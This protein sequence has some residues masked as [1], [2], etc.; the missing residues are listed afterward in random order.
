V[1]R[2]DNNDSTFLRP[3]TTLTTRSIN[4]AKTSHFSQLS[5]VGSLLEYRENVK[6][7]GGGF[8]ENYEIQSEEH[9]C[10]IVV[11]AT[12]IVFLLAVVFGLIVLAF[13]LTPLPRLV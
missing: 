7:K 2:T 13:F 11:S 1:K 8:L 3:Q 5:G 12:S 4:T 10:C 6:R 9:I